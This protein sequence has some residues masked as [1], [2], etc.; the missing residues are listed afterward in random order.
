MQRDREARRARSGVTLV[1]AALVVCIVG[2]LLAVFV[3]TFIRELRTSKISEASTQLASLHRASA[4]YY[5]TRHRD[6]DGPRRVRCLP[7]EAGPVPA[8]TSTAPV[9]VD[10]E[11]EGLAG[12]ET[13]SALGFAPDRPLRYRYSFLPIK[14]GCDLLPQDGRPLLTLRA[15]GD[16]DGDGKLSLFE[17]QATANESGELIPVGVLRIHDRTE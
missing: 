10:F 5:A 12:F 4:A 2:V 13:F 16:L 8:D 14:D 6:G 17:R 15:E 9:E 1:E 7:V 11:D 3:P